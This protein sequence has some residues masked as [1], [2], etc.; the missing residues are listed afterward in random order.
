[1]PRKMHKEHVFM[2]VELSVNRNKSKFPSVWENI[3]HV[4]VVALYMRLLARGSEDHSKINW[5]ESVR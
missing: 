2:D 4:I 3:A 5:F 1:M